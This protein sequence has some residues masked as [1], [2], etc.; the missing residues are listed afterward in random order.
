MRAGLEP[1]RDE[2]RGCAFN[3][4]EW[5]RAT[6]H[7]QAHMSS[8]PPQLVEEEDRPIRMVERER[9]QYFSVHDFMAKACTSQ[10]AGT[11][12]RDAF[13][14]LLASSEDSPELSV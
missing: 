1:P 14:E 12:A 7:H 8:P 5:I 11:S 2:A 10:A 4:R 6:V 3:K 9:P 13:L